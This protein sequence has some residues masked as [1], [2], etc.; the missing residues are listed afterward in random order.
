M[1]IE[2]FLGKGKILKMF[3]G[4]WNFFRKQEGKLKQEENTSLPQGDGRPWI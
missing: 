2:Q 3:H 1:K 4:V